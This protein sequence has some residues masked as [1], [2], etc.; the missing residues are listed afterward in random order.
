MIAFDNGPAGGDYVRYI[1]DL[2]KR[3]AIAASP[4]VLSTSSA[5][6][7]GEARDRLAALAARAVTDAPSSTGWSRPDAQGT[8]FASP[9][10]PS[11]GAT[12]AAAIAAALASGQTAGSTLPLYRKVGIA[13]IVLGLVLIVLGFTTPLSVVGLAGGGVLIAWAVRTM[14]DANARARRIR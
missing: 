11:A 8:G 2:M 3:G 1:D 4:G 14:R 5:G 6:T 12:A 10:P 7:L 13:A 9:P